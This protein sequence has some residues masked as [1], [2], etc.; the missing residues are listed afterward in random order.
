MVTN[1]MPPAERTGAPQAPHIERIVPRLPAG[2]PALAA[3]LV[4]G[5]AVRVL[6]IDSV[7]FNSDEAVYAGQAAS[8]AGD[9]G[10]FPYFPIFRAHPLLFQTVLSLFY[11]GGTSDVIGR[12]VAVG[13][14]MATIAL[15]FELGRTLYGRRVGLLAA[16]IIAVM[17]YQVV[18]T[19]QVLLDG[20]M[21]TFSTLALLLAAKYGR[22]R[23]PAWLVAS[24]AALGLTCLTKETGALLVGSVY[25]FLALAQGL[26]TRPR[27]ALLALATW[28]VVFAP[29]PLSLHFA[30]RGETGQNFLAWQLFRRPNHGWWFYADVVPPALGWGVVAAAVLAVVLAREGSS[31]QAATAAAAAL[32]PPWTVSVVVLNGS[33]D[34]VYTRSVASRIQAMSY[35]IEKVGKASSFNYPQTQVYYPPGGEAIAERLAKQLD[36]P[37]QPL[38]GGT[39]PKRLVVIVGPEKAVGN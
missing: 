29:Y 9:A 7:G 20:P 14:G 38:P 11:Q 35:R 3:V 13:F 17:P 24:G 10:L 4:A 37:M 33:G 2:L 16:L 23:R 31:P 25:A 39:D 28:F 12:L 26:G 34:I 15:T 6:W 27:T 8:I 36:V 18:V 30:K 19:R 1:V 32:P 5:L 21:V 22:T